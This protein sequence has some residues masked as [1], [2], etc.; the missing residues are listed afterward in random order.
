MNFEFLTG[1]NFKTL[2]IT[3]SLNSMLKKSDLVVFCKTWSKSSLAM[4]K[5]REAKR[6][7]S[8]FGG[9][10]ML[11]ELG[12]QYSNRD[13]PG[14]FGSVFFPAAA[15]N[16]GRISDSGLVCHQF[17]VYPTESRVEP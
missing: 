14:A 2:E 4:R 16:S 12:R 1:E 15:G 3:T 9:R 6:K 10:G 7:E 17:R 8:P 11:L 5:V 13:I